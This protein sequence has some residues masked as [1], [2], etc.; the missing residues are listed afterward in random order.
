MKNFLK[1][2][3]VFT[4]LFIAI[5]VL[6][7]V[8]TPLFG[9]SD[10]S[11]YTSV[12]KNIGLYNISDNPINVSECYGISGTANPT[13]LFELIIVLIIGLN[14]LVLSGSVF[15]IHFLGCTYSIIFILSLYF[16]QKNLRFNKDYLNYG[17]SVLLGIVFLDLG[18]IAYF[19]SFYSEAMIFVLV[20]AMTSLAVSVAHKWSYVKIVLFA[21]MAC[22]LACMRFS[23][24]VTAL[25]AAA[26][27]LVIGFADKGKSRVVCSILAVIVAATSVFSMLNPY[28]SARDVKLYNR[29]YK[30]LATTSDTALSELGIADRTVPE[31]PTVED[32]S[33]AV[34]GL[35]YGDICNYY[36]NHPGK[37]MDD[38]ESAINNSYFLIQEFAPYKQTGDYYG[39]REYTAPKI[40]N[41]LKKILPPKGAL[42]IFII[43]FAYLG[44]AIREFLRTKKLGDT[45][46]SR[47]AM[48]AII[49]PVGALAEFVSTVITTGTILISKNMFTFGVYFDLMFITAIMWVACTLLAR[50]EAIKAKY[51]VK[52]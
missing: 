22:V 23:A 21:F 40:W 19:N 8:C 24:A 46:K 32:M 43:I 6:T 2:Y 35:T 33:A 38:A 48:F 44:I 49:L 42:P 11:E 17:F 4:V 14:K 41:F 15:N 37:F 16:L 13:S 50:R 9:M 5:I 28:T 36:V 45:A 12:F 3:N 39:I 7:I 26:A 1:S 51:G 27:L 10:L 29:V 31:N 34:S 30:D 47:M 25:V 52:Q 18:Y 20:I